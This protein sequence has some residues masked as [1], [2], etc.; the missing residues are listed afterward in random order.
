VVPASSCHERDGLRFVS[1]V[2]STAD[3]DLVGEGVLNTDGAGS[4]NTDST[5][6]GVGDFKLAISIAVKT[7]N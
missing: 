6:V 4:F 5:E 7:T 1:R 2:I 3:Y